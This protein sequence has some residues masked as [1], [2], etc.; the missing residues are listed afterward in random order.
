MDIFDMNDVFDRDVSICVLPEF[1]NAYCVTI[2][3]DNRFDAEEQ[4]DTWISKN[5]IN[6]KDWEWA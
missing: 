6:W 3:I 4:V 2:T 5:L 1:G